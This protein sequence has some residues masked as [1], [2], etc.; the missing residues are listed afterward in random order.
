VSTLTNSSHT[1]AAIAKSAGM[2]P[3]QLRDAAQLWCVTGNAE[4][5]GEMVRRANGA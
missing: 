3:R 5:M 4:A 1:L 2:R